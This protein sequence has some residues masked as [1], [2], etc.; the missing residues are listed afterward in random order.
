MVSENQVPRSGKTC[1][2]APRRP[3]SAEPRLSQPLLA[4]LVPLME[5][6]RNSS[7][8]LSAGADLAPLARAAMESPQAVA[9]SGTWE[10]SSGTVALCSSRIGPA[11]CFQTRPETIFPSC[12]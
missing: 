7:K 11:A 2:P 6:S 8:A 10:L 1:E 9:Q 5:F 4:F 12:S 3:I